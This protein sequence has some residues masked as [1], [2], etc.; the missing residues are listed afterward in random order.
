MKLLIPGPVTTR[1][2]VRA[3]MAQDVAP[4]DEDFRAIYAAL[5]PRLAAIANAPASTHAALL[6][7]G[8]GHFVVEAALR[9]LLPPGGRIL[10]PLTGAYAERIVR[11]ARAAGRE[12]MALPI[13]AGR[14]V[15]PAMIAAALAAD[16]TLSHVGLVYSETSTGVVHDPAAIGAAIRAAGRRMILDAVSAFGALPLDLAAQPEI[17]AVA[18]T[19]NKC[20]DGMPGMGTAICRIDRLQ[21]GAGH[22]GSWCLDLADVLAQGG[23]GNGGASRFTPAAQVLLALR[24]ALDLLDAEGGAPGRLLR[25]RENARALYDGMER[26]GLSPVLS[27][28]VQGPIVVNV[29]APDDP[30]WDLQRFVDA[31]KRYGYLISNFYDTPSPSFGGGCSGAITPALLSGFT[32]AAYAARV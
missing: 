13:A 23:K 21:A 8:S 27:R 10:V 15:D 29:H 5:R 22:A 17:D 24:V 12:P 9:S 2:E 19:L 30:G 32:D 4:W 7:Q 28:G 3:A 18:F 14:P 25:Y 26:I 6:L 1:A 31:L 16:P 11:L 20:L